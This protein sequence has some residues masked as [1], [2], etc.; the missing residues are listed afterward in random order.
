MN[1]KFKCKTKL[2]YSGK[3]GRMRKDNQSNFKVNHINC[4][5]QGNLFQV[6]FNIL[7]LNSK[8]INVT[9]KSSLSPW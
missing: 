8:E 3:D 7:F 1:Y 2:F 9:A 6:K 5:M 4:K